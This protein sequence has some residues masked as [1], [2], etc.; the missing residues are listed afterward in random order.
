VLGIDRSA[1]A[2]AQAV[3]ASA[4]ELAAGRLSFRHVAAEEFELQAGE[5]PFDI[6]LAVRVGAFDG[7]H[8][9]AGRQAVPRIV[10]ALAPA[11]RLFI[12]GG[13]PLREIRLSD[14]C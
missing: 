4:E 11:G 3:A 6:A 9:Q 2:I 8:P 13:D 14:F 1:R 10:A 12:D 5:A 7:R